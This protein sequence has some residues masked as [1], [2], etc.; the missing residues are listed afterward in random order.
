M[1]P[2]SER[3]ITKYRYIEILQKFWYQCAGIKY[4]ISKI[5]HGFKYILKTKIQNAGGKNIS[6]D[7]EDSDIWNKNQLM[8]L[9]QFYSYIAGSL[10]V[11]GPQANLQES[12]HSCS[13]NH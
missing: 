4:F 1:W 3:C 2:S 7:R 6:R 11:S 13:H 9:F 10:H 8:S 5:I 12:S